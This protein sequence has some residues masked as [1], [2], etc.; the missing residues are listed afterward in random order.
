MTL[1]YEDFEIGREFVSAPRTVTTEDVDA[2]AAL[3]GDRNPIHFDAAAARTAGFERPV[4]HGVLGLA[5]ATGLAS[6]MELT[7]GTLIALLGVSWRFKAPVYP[8]DAVVLH[9]RVSSRKATSQPGRGVVTFA[10]LLRNQRNEVVQEGELV[11]LVKQRSA[12]EG[13]STD[14]T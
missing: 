11:E 6:R 5:L 10:A 1:H 4:A 7:R 12:D 9:L 2:F 13:R 3:T 14:R 8:G